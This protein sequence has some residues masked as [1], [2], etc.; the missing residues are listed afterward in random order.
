[1]TATDGSTGD[2][3]GGS[4]RGVDGQ[5]YRGSPVVRVLLGDARFRRGW[6]RL[7]ETFPPLTVHARASCARSVRIKKN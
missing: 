5:R 4:A 7:L 1:M 3:P 2:L 6:L